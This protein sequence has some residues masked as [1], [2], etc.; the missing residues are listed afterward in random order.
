MSTFDF[1][2]SVDSTCEEHVGYAVYGTDRQPRRFG[3]DSRIR[4][5]HERQDWYS[6]ECGC[7]RTN[8]PALYALSLLTL[9]MPGSISLPVALVQMSSLPE[10]RVTSRNHRFL[11]M[12]L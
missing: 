1:S 3:G 5:K 6:R 7:Q 4:K 12:S 11:V 8:A 9:R 2:I 10:T